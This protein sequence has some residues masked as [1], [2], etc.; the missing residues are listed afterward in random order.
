MKKNFKLFSILLALLFITNV[1]AR[2]LGYADEKVV[3]EGVYDSVR[4]I[5]GKEVENKAEVDGMSLGAGYEVKAGGKSTYGLYAGNTVDINEE[6]EKDLF[7]AGNEVTLSSNAKVQR[8]IFIAAS[9]V[10]INTD[11]L[12]D[13][14]I[15]ADT[16]NLK[17]VTINGDATIYARKIEFDSTTNIVGTLTYSDDTETIGL[18]KS[19]M[20]SINIVESKEVKDRIVI[21]FK[22]RLINFTF[23]S[24]TAFITMIVLL[25]LFPKLKNRLN[26]PDLSVSSVC[27]NMAIGFGLLLAVPVL[28]LALLFTRVLVPLSLITLAIYLFSLYLATYFAGYLIGNKITS[29]LF[30]LDNMYLSLLFGVLLIKLISLIPTLGVIVIF[31][32][33]IYGL[34]LILDSLIYKEK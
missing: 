11:I 16:V 12:R 22:T 9:K 10:I 23:S 3:Q 24:I 2:E 33:F 19:N 30:K 8:D 34:G 18:N 13:I 26:N 7:V 5:A 4:M 20:G 14:Y 29:K 6:V 17:G 25:L 15:A 31:I 28:C 32:L 21:S 1:N 27:K